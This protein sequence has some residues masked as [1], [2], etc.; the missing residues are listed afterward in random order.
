LSDQAEE[1]LVALIDE[2]QDEKELATVIKME[3]KFSE[4]GRDDVFEDGLAWTRKGM[5]RIPMIQHAVNLHCKS[6]CIKLV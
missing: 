3:D 2:V 5:E 1:F 4:G 6:V